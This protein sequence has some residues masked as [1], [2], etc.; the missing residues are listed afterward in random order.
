MKLIPWE[1]GLRNLGRS[2]LRAVLTALGSTLVVGLVL[3]AGSF[4]AGIER[5]LSSSGD[6]G[7]IMVIANGS[8]DSLLRSE[9]SRRVDTIARGGIRDIQQRLGEQYVSPEVLF[10]PAMKVDPDSF[11][12][13]QVILR[14]VRPVATLVHSQVRITAGRFPSGGE[15]LMIGK[16]VGV[17][18]RATPE[19]VAVGQKLYFDDKPWTIA[20]HFE[21][22]GTVFETELWA[23][24]TSLQNAAKREG[25]SALVITANPELP[26]AAR[27]ENEAIRKRNKETGGDEPLNTPVSLLYDHAD[28]LTSQRLE[29][30]LMAMTE[31]SYYANA[32][33][34]YEPIRMM[35]WATAGLIAMGALLGGLNTMYAAFAARVREMAT[36]QVLGFSRVSVAISLLQESLLATA[37]GG[38]IACGLGKL[39]L[40]G[41][42]V[43]FSTGAIT[44]A[45]DA[46]TIL[47]ALLAGIVLGIAGALLPAW[48]CLRRPIPDALRA[49]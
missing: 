30:E 14:G 29:L 1:Y 17:Q 19:Q 20:G 41:I 5:Q 31:K 7:N 45:V 48:R 39:F 43:R 26:K 37:A 25:I 3:A 12:S 8:Q 21:A 33:K 42:A 16:L 23:P 27:L 35:V 44:M 6:E 46:P 11:K 13:H 40:D 4:L 28:L 15:E 9:I 49:A 36:L 38:L 24:L 2:P 47:I 10:M 18:L 22:P 32:A 34:F